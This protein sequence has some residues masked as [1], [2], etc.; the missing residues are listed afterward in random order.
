MFTPGVANFDESEAI[1]KS[2]LATSW[3]PAAVAIPLISAITGFEQEIIIC[4]KDEHK[5]NRS[6]KYDL[7]SSSVHQLSPQ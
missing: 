5:L 2:Q 3:Q 6:K 7:P 4:I 1:A